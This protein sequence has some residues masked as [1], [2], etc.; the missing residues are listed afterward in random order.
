MKEKKH[1]TEN[2]LKAV[3]VIL[4]FLHS[5]SL[6]S[7]ENS[8]IAAQARKVTLN[9]K[10]Q[11]L[12][13]VIQEIVKQTGAEVVF[14]NDQ[15]SGVKCKN[16]NLNSATVDVALKTVLEGTALSYRNQNGRYVVYAQQTSQQAVEQPKQTSV[17]VMGKIKDI[18][19][20]P[21]P[22]AKVVVKG[23]T[24]GVVANVDG[25][26]EITVKLP[27]T[28]VVSYIGKESKEVVVPGNSKNVNINIVLEDISKLI[29]EVSVVSTGYQQFNR[30]EMVG[31]FSVVK[32]ED[33]LL[34]NQ[35]SDWILV[36]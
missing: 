28:L 6:L 3:V 2:V 32:A 22:F 7:A 20:S 18:E 23:T 34:P 4:L 21:L 29:K 36:F 33:L 10:E 24:Q 25:I 11:P 9:V 26:Y 16:V 17:T 1:F 14:F 35:T 15:M 31:A 12:S 19:G 8:V 13:G 5:G 30:N 27:C